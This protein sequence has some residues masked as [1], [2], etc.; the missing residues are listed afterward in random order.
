M[1]RSKISYLIII[2]GVILAAILI[3]AWYLFS[4]T[5]TMAG[6]IVLTNGTPRNILEHALGR[7]IL[8]SSSVI[9]SSALAMAW[10]YEKHRSKALNNKHEA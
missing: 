4:G 6:D 2:S 7:L 5:V 3:L 10:C 9:A 1:P 8:I